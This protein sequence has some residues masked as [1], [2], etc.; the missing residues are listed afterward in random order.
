MVQF[1]ENIIQ[2]ST[3]LDR[4]TNS[5]PN[6]MQGRTEDRK[7]NMVFEGNFGSLCFLKG[8]QMVQKL[9]QGQP[10][11]CPYIVSSQFN[12]KFLRRRHGLLFSLKCIRDYLEVIGLKI[13][14]LQMYM[15]LNNLS[16]SWGDS[17]CHYIPSRWLISGEEEFQY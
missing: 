8:T 12:L 10:F 3:G 7:T 11:L 1:P 15:F 14:N 17:S 6:S 13:F 2:N 9:G 16:L 4:F 5:S